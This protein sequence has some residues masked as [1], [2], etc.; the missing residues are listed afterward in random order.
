LCPKHH[1]AVHLG[2][3]PNPQIID[4]EK[5]RLKKP[6]N[7]E[8]LEYILSQISN[9]KNDVVNSNYSYLDL[10]KKYNLGMG[11]IKKYLKKENDYEVIE[12]KLKNIGK[13]NRIT[14]KARN[15]TNLIQAYRINQ[16]LS[17][18]ELSKAIGVSLRTIRNWER[19]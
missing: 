17:C 7:K 10:T 16:N 12:E 9:I 13:L 4:L 3:I 14:K 11:T 18:K 8:K 19:I 6:T 15:P 1:K 2:T 5:K